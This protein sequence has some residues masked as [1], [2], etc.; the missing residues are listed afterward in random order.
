V[1]ELEGLQAGY[2][3][4]PVLFDVSMEVQEGE[5]VAVLGPNGAG[6]TSLLRSIMGGTQIRAGAIRFEGLD[7]A[8]LPEHRRAN[9]GIGYVPEGRHV[10]TSLTVEENLR[11][12]AW[13]QRR[14]SGA[15]A[16][17]MD[18]VLELFPRLR[19]RF[20]LRGG[21]LSGGEQQMVALGRALMSRPRLVLVDEPSLGLAP[22]AYE[23]VLEAL[24]RLQNETSLAVLLVEQKA[25]E[26]LELCQRAYVVA[27]GEI[28]ATGTSEEIRSG[29]AL[30][31]AYFG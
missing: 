2:G 25:V 30:E 10:W 23:S 21:L 14:D 29:A 7:L 3:R 31:M 12:G 15:L 26:A 27:G 24:S 11:L 19:E 9:L 22:L 5:F 20:H 18:F 1:L 6:K 17:Q 4:V 28:Q 8:G 13:T 16:E